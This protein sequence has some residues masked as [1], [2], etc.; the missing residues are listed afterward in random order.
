M[1][2]S[3]S[4][5]AQILD[6]TST[7]VVVKASQP[8]EY[9]AV[10]AASASTPD[11]TANKVYASGGGGGG[12]SLGPNAKFDPTLLLLAFVLYMLHLKCRKREE[13]N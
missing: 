4:S 5:D 10:D 7:Y 13:K 6:Q 9:I 3:A 11:S 12:C 2:F 1:L 8:G